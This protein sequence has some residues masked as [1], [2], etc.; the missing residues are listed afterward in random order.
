MRRHVFAPTALF[1]AALA[2]VWPVSAHA[3]G[4]SATCDTT[5][6]QVREFEPT[7]ATGRELP[8]QV[9]VHAARSATM[10]I[11]RQAEGGETSVTFEESKSGDYDYQYGASRGDFYDYFGFRVVFDNVPSLSFAES[12][13]NA[14]LDF[15]WTQQTAD[16]YGDGPS[17]DTDYIPCQRSTTVRHVQGTRP[18]LKFVPRKY[19]P[20]FRLGQ[21]RPC[22][23]TAIGDLVIQVRG[24]GTRKSLRMDPCGRNK[25]HKTGSGGWL[26]FDRR[27]VF[28]Y[29]KPRPRRD[30]VRAY[31]WTAHFGRKRA[32]AGRFWVGADK[33]PGYRIYSDTMSD[34]YWNVCVN[35]G[36]TTWADH[37]RYYCIEPS[38]WIRDFLYR[39]GDVRH[40]WKKADDPGAD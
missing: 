40:W 17:S 14:R 31:R 37:G 26:G 30:T 15:W 21:R 24:P 38:F 9:N 25:F 12:D 11:G 16:G 13:D 8:L 32:H 4:P 3:I 5:N 35:D 27:G 34:E 18:G 39:R 6:V 1:L 19:Y 2:G 28:E 22:A 7:L 23:V 36:R 10:R 29:L 20:Q 33:V